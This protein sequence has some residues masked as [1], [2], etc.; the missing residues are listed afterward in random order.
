MSEMRWILCAVVLSTVFRY[1]FVSGFRMKFR[2]QMRDTNLSEKVLAKTD[3]PE[4]D[5]P[6]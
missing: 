4:M 6:R 3:D 5:Y 2:P 1:I